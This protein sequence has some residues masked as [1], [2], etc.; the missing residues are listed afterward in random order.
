MNEIC[1]D[2]ISRSSDSTGR[3]WRSEYYIKKCMIPTDVVI[4]DKS[5]HLRKIKLE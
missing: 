1:V 2:S 3:N 4:T 5:I